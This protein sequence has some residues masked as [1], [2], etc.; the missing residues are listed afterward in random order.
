MASKHGNHLLNGW[1]KGLKAH[2]GTLGKIYL[3]TFSHFVRCAVG[4][5]RDTY[6]WED[7]WVGDG[8]LSTAFPH[9]YHLSSLKNCSIS[10]FLV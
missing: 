3:P 10:D 7:Q 4:N 1:R 5:G 2:T 9:L 6:F 8:T